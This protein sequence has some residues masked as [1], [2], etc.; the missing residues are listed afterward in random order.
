[1][2]LAFDF[3]KTADDYG[4]HRQG[5]PDAFF[6]RLRALGAAAPGTRILDLGTGTGT[7]ARGLALGGA[8]AVGLDPSA[9]MLGEGRR[10]DADAGVQIARVVARA[11]AAPFR[12]HSFD[13]VTAGQCW[14]WFDRA[15]AAA[16]V[17]R[18]LVPG[19]RLVVAHFDWIPL[20]GNVVDATEKLIQRHNPAWTFA[21]GHGIYP[22]WLRDAAKAGFRDLE[23]FSFDV[24]V[25]YTHEGWRGRIRASAG[26]GPSLSPDAV[27]AFDAE[28]AA[29]LAREFPDEPLA[30][31][32]RV[33]ALVARAPA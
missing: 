18:I 26:V 25:P 2:D 23:T 30:V 28:H 11:E 8:A 33:W 12:A 32:H 29:M 9:A 15:R 17:R 22:V 14:H 3:G 19:G 31:P 5:F 7:L 4:R 20:P 16:E 27:A 24:D 6:A 21:G 13:A 1:V 10:L